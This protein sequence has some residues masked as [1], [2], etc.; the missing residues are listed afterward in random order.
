MSATVSVPAAASVLQF[1]LE[2]RA[3]TRI[4]PGPAAAFA[5]GVRFVQARWVYH[6]TLSRLDGYSER[7]LDDIG[8]EYGIEE[9]ARRA[10]RL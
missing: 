2:S 3:P 4:L 1:P 10:A 8:A 6:T 5:R 7:L 9:F